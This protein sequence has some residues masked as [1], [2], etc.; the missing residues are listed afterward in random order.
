MYCPAAP[1]KALGMALVALV[2]ALALLL[3][4][5]PAAAFQDIRIATEQG[6][7]NPSLVYYQGDAVFIARSTQLKWDT[8]GLKWIVNKAFLC[9]ADTKT[10]SQSR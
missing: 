8:T 4:M 9:S 7:Y 3:P 2:Q 10:F 1:C 5:Q 6:V